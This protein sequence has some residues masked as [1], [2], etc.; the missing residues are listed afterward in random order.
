MQSGMLADGTVMS[1]GCNN[2]QSIHLPQQL[3]QDHLL[4]SSFA[5]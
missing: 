4:Q 3:P 1:A 2:R 5:H